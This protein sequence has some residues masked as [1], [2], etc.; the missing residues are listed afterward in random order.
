LESQRWQSEFYRYSPS[1]PDLSRLLPEYAP[2]SRGKLAS[3][4]FD[5]N[6]FNEFIKKY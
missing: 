1:K 3:P 5:R 4:V 6:S 2:Y